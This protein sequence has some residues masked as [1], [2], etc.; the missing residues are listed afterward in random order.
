MVIV[1]TEAA[2]SEQAGAAS[3]LAAA[4]AR[5]ETTDGS[6]GAALLRLGEGGIQSVLL[7]GGARIH[8]AAAYAGMI[9]EVRLFIAPE[10]LGQGGVPFGG[11][12]PDVA[13]LDGMRTRLIGPDVL[14]TGYVH[15]PH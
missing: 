12:G 13:A 7:E 14:V 10:P 4:G 11:E 5:L 6:F 8:Q 2:L 15:R 9:D 1:T 3:A